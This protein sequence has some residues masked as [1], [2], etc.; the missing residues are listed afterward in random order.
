M[1]GPPEANA[2][3]NAFLAA[4]AATTQWRI[5]GGALE[6]LNDGKVLARF[7]QGAAKP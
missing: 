2:L 3:E 5:E 4:L 7:T 1:A 6:L